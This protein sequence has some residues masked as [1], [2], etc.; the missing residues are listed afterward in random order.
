MTVAS[1]LDSI[2]ERFMNDP[3]SAESCLPTS[4]EILRIAWLNGKFHGENAAHTP[5]GSF[6]TSCVTPSTRAGMTHP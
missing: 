5:T 2:V 6:T 4:A 3:T 1:S